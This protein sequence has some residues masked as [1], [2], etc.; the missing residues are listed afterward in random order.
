MSAHS[1]LVGVLS[2]FDLER[3][4]WDRVGVVATLCG[5]VASVLAVVDNEKD[6]VTVWF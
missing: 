5:M 6:W 2:H 3:C 1:I 4:P